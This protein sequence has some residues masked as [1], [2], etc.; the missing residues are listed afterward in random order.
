MWYE[1]ATKKYN[2]KYV[3]Y[4]GASGEWTDSTDSAQVLY[5][6]LADDF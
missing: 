4:L 2:P 6:I 1:R 5:F 3:Y